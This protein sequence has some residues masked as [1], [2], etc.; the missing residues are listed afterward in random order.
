MTPP[1]EVSAEKIEIAEKLSAQHSKLTMNATTLADLLCETLPDLPSLHNLD[2]D[3]Q[4]QSGGNTNA[5]DMGEGHLWE[6]EDQKTF[7]RDILDLT[8]IV[9]QIL[10]KRDSSK[11][12][13]E[14]KK[15]DKKE[16]KVE[17]KK[18]VDLEEGKDEE[19]IT[20]EKIEEEFNKLAIKEEEEDGKSE[21]V[22]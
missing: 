7:Y 10:Y 17:E 22:R 11:D 3:D 4:D 16:D 1:G 19:E 20:E 12:G 21:I 18:I 6:D 2:E 14:E 13:K 8:G 15:E 5:S 9:P